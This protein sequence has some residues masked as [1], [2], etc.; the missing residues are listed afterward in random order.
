ML[1]ALQSQFNRRKLFAN[2]KQVPVYVS[3]APACCFIKLSYERPGKPGAVFHERMRGT[4][5]HVIAN[6]TFPS[7]RESRPTSLV[8]QSPSLEERSLNDDG[9][10][11]TSLRTGSE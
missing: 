4:E 8:W 6:P 10:S 3:Q 1:F 7:L 11:H 9:D 2:N 5:L